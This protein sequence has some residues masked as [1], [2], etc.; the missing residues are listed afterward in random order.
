MTT[1][2]SL[3]TRTTW[4]EADREVTLKGIG[5]ANRQIVT[6][7]AARE[8]EREIP[9]TPLEKPLSGARVALVSTAGLTLNEDTPFDQEGERRN[10]WW[11]DPTFRVL[12]CDTRTGDA[13]SYHMHIDTSVPERD[14]DSVMPLARLAELESEGFVGASAPSHYSFMGY[15]LKPKELLECSAPAMIER[16]KEESVDAAL[17]VPV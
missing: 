4:T 16:M 10:P 6:A 12:P 7:W 2:T 9:W 5:R 13:T 1:G 14:L 11:G 17:L 15:L 8:P 3:R